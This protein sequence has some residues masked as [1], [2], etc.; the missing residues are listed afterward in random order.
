MYMTWINSICIASSFSLFKEENLFH[1][2]HQKHTALKWTHVFYTPA[3]QVLE[4]HSTKSVNTLSTDFAELLLN[5]RIEIYEEILRL[6]YLHQ[7]KFLSA[8]VIVCVCVCW[9]GQHAFLSH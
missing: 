8:A 9:G 6:F 4:T 3:L 2:R 5:C 7:N 1:Y